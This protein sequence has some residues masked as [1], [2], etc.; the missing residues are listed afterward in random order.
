MLDSYVDQAED[1]ANGDHSYI[2]HY[3]TPELASEQFCL[4]DT[5]LPARDPRA[6]KR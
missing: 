2:A 6:G 1:A 5:P 4:S 3:P